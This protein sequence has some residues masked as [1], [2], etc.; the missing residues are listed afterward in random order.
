MSSYVS[1]NEASVNLDG[2]RAVSRLGGH[3]KDERWRAAI[4]DLEERL[5]DENAEDLQVYLR[6]L[7]ADKHEAEDVSH[8]SFVKID[9]YLKSGHKP[10]D[11]PVAFLFT[12]ARNA[13]IDELRK[14]YRKRNVLVEDI[15]SIRDVA[16]QDPFENVIELNDLRRQLAQHLTPRERDVVILQDI[17]DLSQAQIAAILDISIGTVGRCHFDAKKKLQ[18]L[19]RA[20]SDD[21]EGAGL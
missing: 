2:S 6:F 15:S 1:S 20:G 16:D 8:D 4:A 7:G 19:L 18:K 14:P 5:Y 10:P 3:E 17:C 12:V 13:W 11:D 21:E 9:T